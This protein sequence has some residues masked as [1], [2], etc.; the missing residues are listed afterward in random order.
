MT[1][2]TLVP[3]PT[4]RWSRLIAGP[5]VWLVGFALL[6]LLA[7]AALLY[8]IDD[9]TWR[10][11]ES[12]PASLIAAMLA[13]SLLNYAIR[14]WRWVYLSALLRLQVPWGANTLYYF[15]G[16]AL[17][18]TPG[19]AGEA[20]RLM[21]LRQGHGVGYARSL[22]LMFADRILDVWGVLLLTLWGLAAFTQYR[23]QGVVLG[24]LVVACSIPFLCAGRFER[25]ASGSARWVGVRRAVRL[26]QML[27]LLQSLASWRGYGVALLPSVLGWLAE[28]AALYLLL[29]HLGAPVGLPQAVFVFAFGMIVG[30]ISMLP[31]GLGSTELSM[32][33]LL[34]ALGVDADVAL[35]ATA[36]VR[37]TT[38]WFAV[39]IGALLMP[40]AT[41]RARRTDRQVP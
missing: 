31:G 39:A 27:R 36:V 17:T 1:A 20:V 25:L 24:L 11:L 41:R 35:V 8:W 12:L 32:V 28:G 15:A 10:L 26:R 18:A 21:L 37:V 19:K 2:S 7:G 4:S 3:V 13:L 38:F 5:R 6:Y 34:V 33:G 23:W 40:L 29:Q 9:T 14:A 16:Y 30:A 22:P